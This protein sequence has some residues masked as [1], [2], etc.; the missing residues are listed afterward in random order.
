MSVFGAYIAEQRNRAG[1]TQAAAA[2]RFSKSKATLVSIEHGRVLPRTP[3]E[4]VDLARIVDGD[5][6]VAMS[7]YLYERS[8]TPPWLPEDIFDDAA[9]AVCEDIARANERRAA[10]ESDR[11]ND[12][13]VSAPPASYRDICERVE[14]VFRAVVEDHHYENG[15]LFPLRRVLGSQDGLDSL[16]SGLQLKHPLRFEVAEDGP[17]WEGATSFEPDEATDGFEYVVRARS[18]VWARALAGN[19]RDRFTLAHELSHVVLHHEL[20]GREGGAAAFRDSFETAGETARRHGVAVYRSP[21]WQAQVGASAILMPSEKLRQ[22][23]AEAEHLDVVHVARAF[24]VSRTAA[25]IRISKFAAQ[26]VSEAS[27]T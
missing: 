2:E 4:V 6:V 5:V 18:D 22:F 16:S 12:S 15:F 14:G 19:G 26:Q 23:A 24:G 8:N 3:E 7:K 9:I 10:R 11:P 27:R 17:W 21:E 13:I 25:Q 20:L 1:L